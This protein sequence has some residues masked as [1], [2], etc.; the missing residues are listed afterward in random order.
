MNKNIIIAGV[1]GQGILTIA[2]IIDLAAM[3][4]GLFVKQAEVHG[5]SQRGGEVQ[6]HLRISDQEIFSDLIP[7]G[8]ADLILSVEPMEALRYLPYLSPNGMIVTSTEPFKNIGNYPNEVDLTNTIRQSAKTI[9]VD[10]STVAREV[11]NPKSYNIVMLG[12][13]S[14]FI[15][16]DQTQFEWG[17]AR[18]FASKGDEVIALN[19]AAFRKGLEIAQNFE[20]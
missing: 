4:N 17:I 3:K 15:G 10:A 14:P 16:I 13:A 5:M 6:S 19:I 1:G 12:A 7:L 11:G 8:K 18:L 2:S 9:F 20:K